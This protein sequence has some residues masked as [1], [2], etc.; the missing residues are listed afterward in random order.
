MV[1]TQFEEERKEKKE[2]KKK[3]NFRPNHNTYVIQRGRRHRD[4]SNDTVESWLKS[5]EPA[6][7]ITRRRGKW[8]MHVKHTPTFLFFCAKTKNILRTKLY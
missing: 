4:E 3:N 1:S 5:S 7:R 2:R 8:L 6:A